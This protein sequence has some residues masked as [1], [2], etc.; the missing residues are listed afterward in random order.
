[1]AFIE[2]K[3]PTVLNIKLT[4]KG[5]ELLSKGQ[6]NFKYYA[7]GDSE[8]D[9][10]FNR[11]AEFNPFY[12]NI[13][14]P[15]DKNPKQL[16]FIPRNLSG[17]PYNE[18]S[19][20]PST[21]S[22]IVNQVQPI[23]FF[24]NNTSEFLVDSDHVKQPDIAIEISGIT[25][26]TTLKLIKAPTYQANQNEP[27]EGDL[28]LVKWTN[29]LSINTTGYTINKN[30]PTPILWYKIQNINSGTLAN[31]NLIVEVDREL[32][33]FSE[34]T[35]GSNSILA[36]AMVYY[37]FVNYTGE[38]NYSTDNI[39]EALLTFLQNCQCPTTIFPFWN[40]SI[41]YTED[42][43]G[44][45]PANDISYINYN[46]KNFAGLVSYIQNQQKYNEDYEYKRKLG[47]IHYTNN[48]VSNTYGESFYGDPLNSREATEV[49]TLDIPTIMWHKS[50]GATLGLQLKA[51]GQLKY[52]TGATKFL[53]TRYYD[54]ADSVGNV[55]GKVFYDL[56]I[57]L[58]E[59]QELLF[60]M[61]YKSNRSWT[62]PEHEVDIN[63]N[64][65]FGCPTC[66]LHF[67]T[68][69][70]SPST[71]GGDDGSITISGITNSSL[72]EIS[73]SPVILEILTGPTGST[74]QTKIYFEEITGDTTIT[75]N[76]TINNYNLSAGTYTV[77]L[78]DTGFAY[79]ISGKTVTIPAVSSQLAI[80]EEDTTY[81][82]LNSYFNIMPVNNNPTHIR[83]NNALVGSPFGAAYF[84]ITPTGTTNTYLN[85]LSNST[86]GN[87]A[88]GNPTNPG[89]WVEIPSGDTINVTNLT[90]TQPY[91]I[92]VRDATGNTFSDIMQQQAINSQIW[93]YYVAAGNPLSESNDINVT[94]GND[95]NGDYVVISNYINT[96]IDNSINPIIGD[97]EISIHKTTKLP[98]KWNS[99]PNDGSSVKIYINDLSNDTYNV[100]I[101][102]KYGY[103]TMYKITA[104]NTFTIT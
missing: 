48:S 20:V 104:N 85:S 50:T 86:V 91:Q 49:P 64:V 72:D 92:F 59:D 37:N 17:D 69:S 7:I 102:E 32:P 87:D 82:A 97:I 13:L 62:L 33:D 63:A 11:N 29:P 75:K 22:T 10:D 6:L 46:T 23:G 38:T 68:C 100:S 1:M 76:N 3:D 35:G 24:N 60:S 93:S 51:T 94:K 65:T 14:R 88:L 71:I 42:I 103:I 43:A 83:F 34:I 2:K 5:R 16:S 58:I 95:S 30:Y 44:V 79:C 54:L 18:I 45:D 31:N 70:T 52:L 12:S 67:E 26:G 28:L 25:G 74:G 80:I 98:E 84:T 19:S 41:I 61:S 8:I 55:V 47:I 27:K 56:K 4:S 40:M 53:N 101:R 9:Y 77:R 15:V 78:I 39:D 73:T 21:P 66:P 89:K 81:S 57:F 96:P 36:G 90:F 99:T